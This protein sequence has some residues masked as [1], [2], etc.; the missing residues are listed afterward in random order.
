MA[1]RR[2]LV[3]RVLVVAWRMPEHDDVV[4]ITRELVEHRGRLGRPLLYLSVIGRNGIPQGGVRDEIVGF[5]HSVLANCDSMHIV[6]EGSEFEQSIKRSVIASV[7][8]EV[9]GA[10]GRVIVENSLQ[11]VQMASPPSVRGELS[12]ATQKATEQKLFDFARSEEL[13]TG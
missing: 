5:Y 10:R 3:E 8:L 1:H 9:G 6:I 7:L 13:P 4:T 12:R 2:V 11:S